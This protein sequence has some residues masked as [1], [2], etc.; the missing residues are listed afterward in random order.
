MTLDST[1]IHNECCNSIFACL[2]GNEVD[3]IVTDSGQSPEERAKV[4]AF[5]KTCAEHGVGVLIAGLTSTK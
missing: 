4:E 3:L 1:K 2:S 5:T